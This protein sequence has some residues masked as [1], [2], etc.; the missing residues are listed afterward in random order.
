MG[1]REVVADKSTVDYITDDVAKGDDSP[2]RRVIEG[3]KF[4]E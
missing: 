2:F 3:N 4:M 1:E